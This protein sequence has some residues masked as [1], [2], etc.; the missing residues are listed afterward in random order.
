[1]NINIQA[2]EKY[3]P[4]SVVN[5]TD[6]EKHL[7]LPAGWIEKNSGVLTRNWAYASESV[8][9]MGAEALKRALAKASLQLSDLDLLIAAG[10]SYDHPIPFNAALI[11]KQIDT[12]DADTPCFDID[13]TCLSFL[14]ALDIAHLY[15]QYRGL[16]RVAIVNAEI[17][18]R[19]LDPNDPKTYSLFGDA[20]IAVILE[21]SATEGYQPI[22]TSFKNY[23]QGVEY[24]KIYAGGLVKQGIDAV[25]EEFYFQMQGKHMIKLTLEKLAGFMDD[26]SRQTHTQLTE[27]DFVLPHQTSRIGNELFI[28]TYNLDPQKIVLTLPHYGNCISASIPLGLEALYKSQQLTKGDKILLAGSAAGL[29]LGAIAL[30]F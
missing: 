15:L 23:T 27:Y 8:S 16:K 24:A 6:L 2:I 25:P 19:N 28:R 22:G 21:A 7:Q 12:E 14:H 11:K 10:A 17:A 9:S 13:S 5:S 29:S 18:S 26:F 4:G 20:A 30:Q 1:M 3:M